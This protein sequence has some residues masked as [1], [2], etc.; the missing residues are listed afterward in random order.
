MIIQITNFL[1]HKRFGIS[2]NFVLSGDLW[3]SW[4]K[5][6]LTLWSMHAAKWTIKKPSKQHLSFFRTNF[7]GFAKLTFALLSTLPP[8]VKK[9]LF[10]CYLI[11]LAFWQVILSEIEKKI[12]YKNLNLNK[13]GA[14]VHK[15][16]L[17]K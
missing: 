9:V 8:G 6:I 13:N 7:A 16:T 15:F 1:F 2:A 4:N 14:F 17:I 10:L 5:K 12:D 11:F 3:S